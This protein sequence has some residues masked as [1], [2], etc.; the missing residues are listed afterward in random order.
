MYTG[1]IY[2]DGFDMLTIL[3]LL[4][5]ANKFLLN[6]LVNYL[7]EN[8]LSHHADKMHQNM[9]L[10]H[11]TAFEHQNSSPFASTNIHWC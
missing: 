4:I 9:A 11:K 3:D 8:L 5:A 10:I 7:Q 6:D 2:L 1:E